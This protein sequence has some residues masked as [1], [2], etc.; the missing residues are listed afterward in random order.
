MEARGIEPLTTTR[1]ITY[2]NKVEYEKRIYKI[3]DNVKLFAGEGNDSFLGAIT[4]IYQEHG[5][6]MALTIRWFY[7][8]KDLPEEVELPKK[9]KTYDNELLYSFHEDDNS[10]ESLETTFDVIYFNMST[11]VNA[12]PDDVAFVR[13][14]YDHEELRIVK[15]NKDA[16]AKFPGYK[17]TIKD[18][19]KIADSQDQTILNNLLSKRKAPTA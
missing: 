1:D 4:K 6:D 8:W 18:L 15:L 11:S 9:F 7:K 13:Y 10:T 3:G 5:Q 2:Y 14:L 17:R 16:I 12:V 19:L